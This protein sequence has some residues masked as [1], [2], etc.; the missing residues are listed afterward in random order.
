MENGFETP[1]NTPKF[2]FFIGSSNDEAADDGAAGGEKAGGAAGS[3]H[4]ALIPLNNTR[5][6]TIKADDSEKTSSHH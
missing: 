3:D 2:N 5:D 1:Y 6:Q 4:E